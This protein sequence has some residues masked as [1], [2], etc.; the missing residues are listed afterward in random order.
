VDDRVESDALGPLG[1]HVELELERD[2]SLGHAFTNEAEDVIERRIG[3]GLRLTDAADLFG[4]LGRAQRLDPV[5]DRDHLGADQCAGMLD[6]GPRERR[7][8]RDVLASQ[9]TEPR[10]SLRPGP[11]RA[12]AHALHTLNHIAPLERPARLVSIAGRRQEPTEGNPDGAILLGPTREI[13]W[14]NRTAATWLNLPETAAF[15]A[16]RALFP[17]GFDTIFTAGDRIGFAGHAQSR[18]VLIT[19]RS[20]SSGL[21]GSGWWS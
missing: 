20:R 11:S 15:R 21:P 18:G 12:H 5:D 14:F 16:N 3:Q 19:W 7:F 1:A 6:P 2:L 13:L 10:R 9:V 8:D 4:V 17:L